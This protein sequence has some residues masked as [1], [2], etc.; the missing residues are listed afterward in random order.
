[1][2]LA[3]HERLCRSIRER[4]FPIWLSLILLWVLACPCRFAA[5]Q[6]AA[7]AEPAAPN[8][9]QEKPP[10]HPQSPGLLDLL[11]APFKPKA[12]PPL[13]RDVPRSGE[14]AEAA[15]PE[16]TIVAPAPAAAPPPKFENLLTWDSFEDPIEWTIE[17]A[18]A[19]ATLAVGANVSDGDRS[20]RVA[21]TNIGRSD[22]E[23]R[24]EIRL[25][26]TA[27]EAMLLDVYVDAAAPMKISAVFRVGSSLRLYH[28]VPVDLVKGWNRD[29][30]FDLRAEVFKTDTSKGHDTLFDGRDDIRRVSLTVG[31]GNNKKGA[32]EIDNIRFAGKPAQGWE[33]RRPQIDEV[34]VVQPR[35]AAKPPQDPKS[36]PAAI[37]AEPRLKKYETLVL[38]VKFQSDYVSAFDP[39]EISLTGAFVE[40]AGKTFTQPGYLDGLRAEDGAET[41]VWLIKFTPTIPGRWEYFV[42]VRNN[43]SEAVSDTRRFSVDE[44]PAGRGFIRRSAADSRYFEFDDGTFFYPIGQN[45]CWT[46]NYETHFKKMAAAGENFVRIWMCPW[47]LHLEGP[48]DVGLYDLDV[49]ERIDEIFEQARRYGIYVQLVF[50][51]HGMLNNENWARN[52]YNVA[53]GGPCEFKETFFINPDAKTLFKRRMRYIAARWGASP[54][55]FAWELMNE[56]DLTDSY[57]DDDIV[58][59]HND[60]SAALKSYDA[61]KHLVTTSAYGDLLGPKLVALGNIDFAQDHV[62]DAKALDAVLAAYDTGSALRAKPYFIGEF[63]A[64]TTPEVDQTDRRGV[65][66]HTTLWASF[67]LPTAGNAMPWW[68]DTFI[69][70]NNLYYH[71]RA[72]ANF[73]KDEDRRGKSYVPIRLRMPG[74]PGRTLLVLGMMTKSEA[75]FWVVD[76]VLAQTPSLG[77]YTRIPPKL[78]F[79]FVGL[80]PGDYTA[81]F[82]DTYQGKVFTSQKLSTDKG[83]LKLELPEAQKDIACKLKFSG[84]LETPGVVLQVDEQK[85]AVKLGAKPDER[86]HEGRPTPKDAAKPPEP[87]KAEAKK[88]PQDAAGKN[89]PAAPNPQ[90]QTAKP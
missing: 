80:E 79:W 3:L 84:K 18:Q 24:R 50:E 82:W 14:P 21:F 17:A 89:E 59:W 11:A 48:K 67:M 52:P 76:P 5:A 74:A 8:D 22:I 13:T 55:L 43:H 61:H 39:A 72:L 68:W 56:A 90:P 62:Y 20:L 46:A 83:R 2:P 86:T 45:V 32:V 16:K 66:L 10:Q 19:P 31:I 77:Q 28:S 23:L 36:A 44:K 51:Y 33:K 60:M 30:V 49:A 35:E 1:M 27:M 69:E 26:L 78:G 53:N 64:G 34:S 87:Q 47:H 25:D 54:N 29:V 42:T 6:Q 4:L 15:L 37:P 57:T 58:A 85:A 70:P 7:P 71:W 9:A 75:M 38:R 40:P 12:K 65:L 41:P 63:G 73:A 88:E 81:E